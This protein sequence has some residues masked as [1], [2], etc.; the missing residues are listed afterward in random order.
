MSNE[1]VYTCVYVSECSHVCMYACVYMYLCVCIPKLNAIIEQQTIPKPRAFK[2][3]IILKVRK[4]SRACLGNSLMHVSL[5]WLFGSHR[6]TPGLVWMFKDVSIDTLIASMG[7][8]GGC[9]ALS[10]GFSMWSL[11]WVARLLT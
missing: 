8:A 6:V 4:L 3:T 2:T 1:C 7:R 11:R 10:Q 5:T 9:L